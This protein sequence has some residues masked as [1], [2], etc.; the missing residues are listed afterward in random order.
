MKSAHD[1]L[2]T[3][4]NGER[5]GSAGRFGVHSRNAMQFRIDLGNKRPEMELLSELARVE[6]SHRRCLDF[7]GVDL[8]IGDRFAAG[9]RDQIPNRFAFLLQV[10]LKIGPAAA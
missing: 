8:S 3:E 7:R 6:I 1:P 4:Q 10:A 9:F 5:P 2:R